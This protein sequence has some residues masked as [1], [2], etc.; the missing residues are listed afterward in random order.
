MPRDLRAIAK[1][2]GVK[3]LVEGSVH[4]DANRLRVNA[5]LIDATTGARRWADHYDR[6]VADLFGITEELASAIA[7]QT[8]CPDHAL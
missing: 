7:H 2:L 8:S 5:Q 1:A 6:N 3:Y 4:R